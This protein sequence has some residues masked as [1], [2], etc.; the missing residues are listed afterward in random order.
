RAGRRRGHY[1]TWRLARLP[2]PLKRRPVAFFR[3]RPL[4]QNKGGITA[5]SRSEKG[6]QMALFLFGAAIVAFALVSRWVE[7]AP[8]TTPMFFVLAG[9]L[10]GPLGLGLVQVDI[11]WATL[12]LLAEVTL[13]I[14]L[15]TDAA[16]INV[17]QLRTEHNLP[18]RMLG[19]GLPLT[20]VDGALAGYWLFPEL[21]WVGLLVLGLNLAPTDAAL[22]QAVVNNHI[23]PV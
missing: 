18:I 5:R 7:R 20:V 21:G 9:M 14:I 10:F 19:C 23:V 13:A 1:A 4:L 15:F 8:V 12:N 11:E 17:G 6:S 2:G 3:P 22:G 16:R